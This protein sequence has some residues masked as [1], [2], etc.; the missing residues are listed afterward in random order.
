MVEH[1]DKMGYPRTGMKWSLE[2]NWRDVRA[3]GKCYSCRLW[4]GRGG[5]HKAELG[6]ETMWLASPSVST[7]GP[8]SSDSG[9]R[10]PTLTLTP[11]GRTENG[12]DRP[13]LA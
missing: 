2:G 5:E 1:G 7:E 9:S 11:Q 6:N 13:V 8:L 3:L 4:F 12:Q 10:N